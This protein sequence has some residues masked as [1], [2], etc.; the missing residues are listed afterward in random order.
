MDDSEILYSI[1]KEDVSRI[2]EEMNQEDP[3]NLS[4][5][6]SEEETERIKEEINDNDFLHSTVRQVIKT[7][8]E[9]VIRER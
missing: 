1:T 8:I 5:Y 4:I 6:M 9:E 3:Q 2:Y 7:I